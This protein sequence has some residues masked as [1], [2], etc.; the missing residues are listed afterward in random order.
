MIRTLPLVTLFACAPAALP[1]LPS[2]EGSLPEGPD[3]EGY[4]SDVPVDEK[5]GPLVL[6]VGDVHPG[7]LV[8][9]GVANA[10]PGETVYFASSL[11]GI[12][13]GPCLPTLGGLCLDLGTQT[14]YSGSTIA[15]ANGIADYELV[16]PTTLVQGTRVTLQAAVRRGAGG[17]TSEK[18][19]A[20][21]RTVLA[22]AYAHTVTVDGSLA[23]WT[24]DELF[25][26]TSGVGSGGVTWDASTLYVSFDHPDVS[27]GGASHWQ[28]AYF[29]SG[30]PGSPVGA[31]LGTQTPGLPFEAELAV[32]RK[33]DGSYDDLLI[34]DVAGQQWYSYP[35]LTSQGFQVAESGTQLEIGIPRIYVSYV[36][37]VALMSVYEGAGFESSYAGVPATAFTDG[38]DPDLASALSFDLSLPDAPV[39]QNP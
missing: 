29:G 23:D 33:S 2:A 14:Y 16:V 32:R 36:A 9:F 13:N 7:G 38:Y 19:N 4:V 3:L 35:N 10:D 24:A 11:G 26:T 25:P 18:S 15:D 1:E 34:W 37:D 30:R 31:T 39:A 8:R 20:V 5:V 12:A 6:V 27:T 21:V 22:P 17:A 28:V